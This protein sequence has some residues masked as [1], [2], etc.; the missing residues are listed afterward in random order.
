MPE[1]FKGPIKRYFPGY[2]ALSLS[3]TYED[4][5]A[6]AEVR[7]TRYAHSIRTPFL[8]P[9]TPLIRAQASGVETIIHEIDEVHGIIGR[10]HSNGY[11]VV[12]GYMCPC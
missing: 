7:L 5:V 11:P 6:T 9:V 4:S 10:R 1:S 8:C 2:K 12:A 3:D